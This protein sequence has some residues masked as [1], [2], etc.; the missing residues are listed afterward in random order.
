MSHSKKHIYKIRLF[1]N[2]PKKL[3]VI[4]PYFKL[5]KLIRDFIK[6]LG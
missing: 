5:K 2:K 4:V 6:G 1:T 3:Q